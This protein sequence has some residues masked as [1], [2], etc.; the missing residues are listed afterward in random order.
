M[1]RGTYTTQAKNKWENRRCE[2]LLRDAEFLAAIQPGGVGDYPAA[3][4][5]EAWKLV[6]LNQFH[7]IIPGSSIQWVYED[8]ARDYPACTRSPKR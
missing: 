4:L 1:H 8:S 5:E 3:E 7:D 6:L 2:F